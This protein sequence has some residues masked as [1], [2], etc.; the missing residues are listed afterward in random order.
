MIPP[1]SSFNKENNLFQN[2]RKSYTDESNDSFSIQ[3]KNSNG[4]NQLKKFS[5]GFPSNITH[6]VQDLSIEKNKSTQMHTYYEQPKTH[7]D[8]LNKNNSKLF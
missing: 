7:Q 8:D 6:N 3:K 5:S 1:R 4:V 2:F